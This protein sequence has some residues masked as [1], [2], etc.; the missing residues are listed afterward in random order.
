MFDVFVDLEGTKR[1]T[2]VKERSSEEP[3]EPRKALLTFNATRKR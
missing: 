1:N 3:V 2:L